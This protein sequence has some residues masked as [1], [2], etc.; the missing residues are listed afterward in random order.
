ADKSAGLQRLLAALT[1][2]MGAPVKA[3]PRAD[4][5]AKNLPGGEPVF[6]DEPFGPYL[7]I[8]NAPGYSFAVASAAPHAPQGGTHHLRRDVKDGAPIWKVYS[9]D[10][11]DDLPSHPRWSDV[12]ALVGQEHGAAAE[13]A[14]RAYVFG[15]L[16]TRKDHHT[17]TIPDDMPKETP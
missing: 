5:T 7:G 8:Q 3:I 13:Q 4:W 1:E 17:P 15:Y 9:V 12:L 16:S 6:L 10:I 2:V 11:I 14:A